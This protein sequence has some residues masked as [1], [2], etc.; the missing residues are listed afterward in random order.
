M[1]ETSLLA[2]I[3]ARKGCHVALGRRYGYL[4]MVSPI[5]EVESVMVP[6]VMPVES[7]IVPVGAMVPVFPVV[8]A[9]PIPVVS[10]I[11]A[12]PVLSAPYS[13]LPLHPAATSRPPKAAMARKFR[14]FIVFS[15]VEGESSS[16]TPP[17]G[18]PRTMPGESTDYSAILCN[19]CS[20]PVKFHNSA[21]NLTHPS[22][23]HGLSVELDDRHDLGGRS[24]NE[25]LI[26]S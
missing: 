22:I 24:G 23:T 18:N 14:V 12:V 3:D 13:S 5:V 16:D 19:P 1:R 25:E 11:A 2:P 10:P 21:R 15:L 9:A 4:F 17:T 6:V 8:P 7:V 26:H 20:L